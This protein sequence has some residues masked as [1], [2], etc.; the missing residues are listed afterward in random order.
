M[1]PALLALSLAMVPAGAGAGVQTEGP[2]SAMA[3]ASTLSAF[4]QYAPPKQFTEQV[5]ETFYLPMR[6]GT[7]LAVLVA[8]PAV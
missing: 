1:R 5:T 3:P 2:A 6:D 4:G 7:L 8:R